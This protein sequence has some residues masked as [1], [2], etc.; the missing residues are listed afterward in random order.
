MKALDLLH[1][2]MLT[3]LHHRTAM[4]IKM[5]SDGGAFVCRRHLFQ[6]L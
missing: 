3:V 4:T 1:L 2:A 6:L 5:A